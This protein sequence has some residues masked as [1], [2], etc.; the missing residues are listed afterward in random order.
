M[1]LCGR[2]RQN[3]VRISLAKE[4]KAHCSKIHA[5]CAGHKN[6][7]TFFSGGQVTTIQQDLYKDLSITLRNPKQK[8]VSTVIPLLQEQRESGRCSLN[9]LKSVSSV[10]EV[11]VNFIVAETSSCLFISYLP[12]DP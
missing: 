10:F 1:T 5:A 6:R 12:M 7:I 9:S 4:K 11:I 8:R 2:S 3:Y